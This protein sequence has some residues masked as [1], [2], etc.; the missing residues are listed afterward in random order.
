VIEHLIGNLTTVAEFVPET[1]LCVVWS[2]LHMIQYIKAAVCSATSLSDLKFVHHV[3][4]S[5]T[6][7]IPILT[8]TPYRGI[9]LVY[10][11]MNFRL[12]LD[13]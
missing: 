8:H 1:D 2:N 11:H 9:T 3:Q 5:E 10:I 13:N 4:S 6:R 12:K 7:Q